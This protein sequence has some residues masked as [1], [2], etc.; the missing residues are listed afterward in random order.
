MKPTPPN[1]LVEHLL[2]KTDALGQYIGDNMPREKGAED[3][4]YRDIPWVE[5]V[6]LLEILDLASGDYMTVAYTT[7]GIY[8]RGQFLFSPEAAERLAQFAK[9]MLN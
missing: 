5:I 7:K 6:R 4:V 3:W 9:S 1:I 2:G 8:G